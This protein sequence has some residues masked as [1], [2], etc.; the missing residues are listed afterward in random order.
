MWSLCYKIEVSKF[1]MT[2]K[3]TVV[4]IFWNTLGMTCIHGHHQQSMVSA[5]RVTEV[6]I[7]RWHDK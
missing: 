3:Q 6:R 7:Y 1:N 2:R 5:L 4:L